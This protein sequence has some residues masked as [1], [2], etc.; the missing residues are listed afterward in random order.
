MYKYNFKR[1][2]LNWCIKLCFGYISMWVC[3]VGL[4]NFQRIN[5]YP[6]YKI[7]TSLFQ[8]YT[9]ISA[10]I[11]TLDNF[12]RNTKELLQ[13]FQFIKN[14]RKS[15]ESLI[16]NPIT[17][18]DTRVRKN[19]ITFSKKHLYYIYIFIFLFL[20]NTKK[21]WLSISF[22]HSFFGHTYIACIYSTLVEF[23]NNM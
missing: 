6:F 11:V 20:F 19:I 8:G 10:Y 16:Y 9:I 2:N 23:I 22:L 18:T 3:V 14:I 17:L 21:Q 7:N 5:W 1:F 12:R 15:R 4:W 13:D